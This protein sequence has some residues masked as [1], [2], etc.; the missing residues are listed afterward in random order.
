MY[1]LD[2]TVGDL[3]GIIPNHLLDTLPDGPLRLPLENLLGSSGV[4]SSSL[5]VVNG[6]ILVDNVDPLGEWVALFLL[7]FLDDIPDSLGEFHNGEL[8]TVTDVD[9]SRVG[10]VHEENQTVNE[11]VD[12]LE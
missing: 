9:G 3:T 12:V 10:S 5:R 2:L 6:H 1:P 4:G 7:N 8:I 11:I